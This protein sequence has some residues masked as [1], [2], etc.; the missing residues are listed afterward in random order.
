VLILGRHFA[1]MDEASLL[2]VG[3]RGVARTAPEKLQLLVGESAVAVATA[4]RA[5]KDEIR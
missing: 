4:L 1:A 5:L 2:A 3:V